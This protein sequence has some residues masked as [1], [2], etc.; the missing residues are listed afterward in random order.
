VQHERPASFND[1]AP[2]GTAAGIAIAVCALATIVAVAHH[3]TV[4]ARAPAQ[5]MSAM[6]R[7]ATADRVVHGV[8]IAVLAALLYGFTVFSLRRG[9]HR[10][11]SVAGLVAYAIGIVALIGAGL[12]DGFLFPAL[13]E[14]YAGAPAD[15]AQ[16]AV[17][18]LV[19][20]AAMVQILS[21]LGLV[22]MSAGVALWSADLVTTPGVL[23]TTGALGFVFGL[24]TIGVVAFAGHL[25]P[26]SLSAIVVVQAVWYVAVAALLVRGRV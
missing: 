11:T 26:H 9:L 10:D 15:A 6:L 13:A 4:S 18:V 1:G 16:A 3:P 22:A 12:I 20:G 23:R 8:L 25:N 7:I 24:G 5:A 2:G 19:A 17:P 21:K 14:R